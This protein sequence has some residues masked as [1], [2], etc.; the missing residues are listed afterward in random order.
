MGRVFCGMGG[1]RE[2]VC[3]LLLVCI[4]TPFLAV[5]DF[6]RAG[7]SLERDHMG[8]VAAVGGAQSV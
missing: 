6:L 5:N 2:S 3:F 1:A 8:D 4:F 7:A